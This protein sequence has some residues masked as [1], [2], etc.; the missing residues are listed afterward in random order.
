LRLNYPQAYLAALVPQPQSEVLKYCPY[1]DDVIEFSHQALRAQLDDGANIA[2]LVFK[3]VFSII[4]LLRETKFDLVI[5]PFMDFGAVIAGLIKPANV[6]GRVMTSWGNYQVMGE[7]AAKFY[8]LMA[9]QNQLRVLSDLRFSDSAL[10]ILKD[11]GIDK[12]EPLWRKTELFLSA[13]ERVFAEGFFRENGITS[14]NYV[15]GFQAGAML[16]KERLWPAEKFARLANKFKDDEAV[17]IILLGTAQ[18]RKMIERDMVPLLEKTCV[19]AAGETD[20]LESG[21]LVEKLDL[22]VS[23]DTGPMHMAA[24]LGVPVVALFGRSTSIV[25]EAWPNGNEHTVIVENS[26]KDIPVDTV[27]NAVEQYMNNKEHKEVRA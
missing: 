16:N 26:T 25:N 3:H 11:I 18:E 21:A 14:D 15:I 4:N 17:K 7:N 9:K 1:L 8:Y 2:E 10:M 24:A 19:I 22:L 20:L 5:N 23:N 27:F 13:E 12:E 6:L